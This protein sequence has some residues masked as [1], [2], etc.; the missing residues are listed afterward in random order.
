MADKQKIQIYDQKKS[1]FL[2]KDRRE[3]SDKQKALL[4]Y[5][6]GHDWW[7]R[8]AER[9]EKWRRNQSLI[10]DFMINNMIILIFK[11]DC[12]ELAAWSMREN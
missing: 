9:D 2:E 8:K 10:S 5:I 11:D 6:G 1:L 3:D 12:K 7:T 4:R